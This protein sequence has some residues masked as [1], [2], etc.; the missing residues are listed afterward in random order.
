M[1][2]F[3]NKIKELSSFFNDNFDNTLNNFNSVYNK[4]KDDNNMKK[5][6]KSRNSLIFN[7]FE[8]WKLKEYTDDFWTNFQLCFLL[9]ELNLENKDKKFISSLMRSLDKNTSSDITIKDNNTNDNKDVE[10]DINKINELVNNIDKDQI[11][12][13]LNKFN[14]NNFIEKDNI[15][16]IMDNFKNLNLNKNV[17]K[18]KINVISDV[19]DDFINL[20]NSNKIDIN[21]IND[22]EKLCKPLIDKHKDLNLTHEELIIGVL[23]N[24]QKIKKI[25]LNKLLNI[26]LKLNSS[27][28]LNNFNTFDIMKLMNNL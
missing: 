8:F 4:I 1:E 12:N 28:L 19:L 17:E 13:L 26:A 16:N 5:L 27:G 15:N 25:N 2:N 18:D 22:L 23:K 21:S 9:N 6:I 11:N 24:K 14:L 7:N 10:D 3:N 20:F